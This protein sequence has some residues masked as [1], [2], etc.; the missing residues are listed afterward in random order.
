MKNTTDS[1]FETLA[2]SIKATTKLM[3]KLIKLNAIWIDGG[4]RV[5]NQ[6]S[7]PQVRL[8]HRIAKGDILSIEGDKL[9]DYNTGDNYEILECFGTI[10]SA[11]LQVE[12]KNVETGEIK[13]ITI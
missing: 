12:V 5:Y 13:T 10:N 11:V 9:N 2:N 3:K 1:I 6:F 8:T 4:I 7:T